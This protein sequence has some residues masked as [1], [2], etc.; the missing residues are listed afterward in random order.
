[1]P[2]PIHQPVIC[3]YITCEVNK[4]TP[5]KLRIK[6]NKLFEEFASYSPDEYW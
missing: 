5:S 2:F 4:K 6:K 3:H 1:M